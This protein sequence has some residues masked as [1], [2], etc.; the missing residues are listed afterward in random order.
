ML[1]GYLPVITRKQCKVLS[2]E[3]NSEFR[4]RML[5]VAMNKLTDCLGQLCA[6]IMYVLCADG[7]IR[8]CRFF[9]QYCIM[10]GM[11][12][13]TQTGCGA[14]GCGASEGP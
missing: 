13:M 1:G 14:L 9:L 2:E 5:Q 11:E 6:E 12:V 8:K 10:D 4:F 3:S 7:K